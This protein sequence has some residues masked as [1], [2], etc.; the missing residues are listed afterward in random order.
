MTDHRLVR[1]ARLR[2]A[3]VTPDDVDDLHALSADPRVWTHFPSG[4]HLT[5]ERTAAQVAV[6]VAGWAAGLGY[7][8]LRE[9]ESGQF[10]GVGGAAVTHELAWNLYYRIRP[11]CQGNGYAS[12]LVA[13]AQRAAVE[14]RPELPVVAYLVEHNVASRRTAERAGLELRWRGPDRGNPDPDA[15]RLVYADRELDD[16]ALTAII[17]R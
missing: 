4:R 10:V 8:T 14:V 15:V 9:R 17:G 6:F 13:A 12:E 5:R 1:T 3:A 2:L 16:A 7:W 11:E